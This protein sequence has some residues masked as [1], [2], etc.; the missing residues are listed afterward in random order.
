MLKVAKQLWHADAFTSWKERQKKKIPVGC[1]YYE[2]QVAEGCFLQNQQKFSTF[3]DNVCKVE[4]VEMAG[5]AII[6]TWTGLSWNN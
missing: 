3:K 2:M 4:L 1:C 6:G 5:D